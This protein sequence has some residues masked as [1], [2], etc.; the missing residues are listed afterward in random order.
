MPHRTWVNAGDFRPG[1][2]TVEDREII[3]IL[4]VEPGHIPSVVHLEVD[5]ERRGR[6]GLDLFRDNRR[7]LLSRRKPQ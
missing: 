2:V 4:G 7:P 3:H 6:R 1:D 5:G